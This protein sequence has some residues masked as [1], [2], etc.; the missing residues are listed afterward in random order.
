M[1]DKKN[2]QAGGPAQDAGDPVHQQQ[3]EASGAKGRG[4]CWRDGRW[5]AEGT[6]FDVPLQSRLVIGG[7]TVCQ[8]GQWVFVP[9]LK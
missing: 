3:T 5:Y 2:E 8:N 1:S 7:Y 4:G 9:K 6:R